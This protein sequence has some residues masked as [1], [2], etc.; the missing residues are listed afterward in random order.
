[1]RGGWEPGGFPVSLRVPFVSLP[2]LLRNAKG[3]PVPVLDQRDETGQSSL[4]QSPVAQRERR[5]ACVAVS[6]VLAREAPAELRLKAADLPGFGIPA[7]EPGAPEHASVLSALDH[8]HADLPRVPALEPAT[9]RLLCACEI[10]GRPV[11][12]EPHRLG[13][14][15]RLE[16]ARRVLGQRLP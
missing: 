16:E 7:K 5:L 9:D 12:D 1:A 8:E 15:E 3:P 14:G 13:I 6:P 4:V 2:A 10:G 11:A